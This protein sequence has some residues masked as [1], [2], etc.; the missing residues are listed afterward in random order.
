MPKKYRHPQY[1]LRIPQDLKDYLTEQSKINNSTLNAEIINRLKETY[2][3]DALMKIKR[4]SD[5]AVKIKNYED[6]LIEY[7]CL[8][9]GS[10]D[11]TPIAFPDFHLF[12]DEL[13]KGKVDREG[14]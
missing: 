9:L 3:Q 13:S 1:N 2:K 12:V 11:I 14:K 5:S 10:K 7:L 6:L 8:S 4:E